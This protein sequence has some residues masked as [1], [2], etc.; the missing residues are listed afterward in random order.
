MEPLAEELLWDAPGAE[1]EAPDTPQGFGL[2]CLS[3]GMTEEVDL[4]LRI[5]ATSI[6]RTVITRHR[7]RLLLLRLSLMPAA[8]D[9]WVAGQQCLPKGMTVR[10]NDVVII[11]KS[12]ATNKRKKAHKIEREAHKMRVFV[13]AFC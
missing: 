11:A 1:E 6:P 8:V 3:K 7:V 13:L 5:V 4:H 2:R 9:T 10:I 12:R